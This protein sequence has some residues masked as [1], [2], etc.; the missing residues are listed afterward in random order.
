[1]TPDWLE[2]LTRVPSPLI[3]MCYT[4]VFKN[5]GVRWRS[6]DSGVAI[7]RPL[8][9]SSGF[10]RNPLLRAAEAHCVIIPTVLPRACMSPPG[11]RSLQECCVPQPGMAKRGNHYLGISLSEKEFACSAAVLSLFFLSCSRTT[12]KEVEGAFFAA[13]LRCKFFFLSSDFGQDIS[14]PVLLIMHQ[15]P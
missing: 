1:M 14:V 2:A 13:I 7:R 4:S 11:R 9:S 8:R 15:S 3:N 12:G 10:L 6:A 5:S